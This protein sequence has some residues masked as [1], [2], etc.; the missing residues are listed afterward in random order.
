MRRWL[1]A[2]A[3]AVVVVPAVGDARTLRVDTFDHKVVTT[4]AALVAD[5]GMRPRHLPASVDI[6]L[7]WIAV[8]VGERTTHYP[9]PDRI[10]WV[11]AIGPRL[12]LG[13]AATREPANG[14]VADTIAAIDLAT[15]V[16]A[17]R[18]SL[19][20]LN[21]I[22]LSGDLF[23][24]ERDGW[25]EVVDA[26]TGR[27]V[28]DTPVA[29]G[30]LI[31]V[32]RAGGGAFYVR[33]QQDLIALSRSGSVRW[34]QPATVSSNPVEVGATVVDGWVDKTTN[35]FGLVAYDARTGCKVDA[36]DLGDTGGWYD[37]ARVSLAPDGPHEVL[38]S[39]LFA[40]E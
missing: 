22:E 25:I 12:V 11:V 35:R 39:A 23:V 26:R 28:A 8:K 19:A 21:A 20:S 30:G 14:Q 29:G 24:V 37:L 1:V 10:A 15:G 13:Y 31:S 40:V 6:S 5:R 36:I 17:W 33:T 4:T 27:S 2:L 32:C 18:R 7:R 16:V 3:V 38:V 9:L 34:T